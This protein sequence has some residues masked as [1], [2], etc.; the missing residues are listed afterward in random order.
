MTGASLAMAGD[1]ACVVADCIRKADEGNGKPLFVLA[2]AV[3]FLHAAEL[4]VVPVV[5]ELI[6]LIDVV[7]AAA[8]VAGLVPVAVFALEGLAVV[9]AAAVNEIVTDDY[10]VSVVAAAVSILHVARVFWPQQP[11]VVIHFDLVWRWIF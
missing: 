2:V 6:D 11:V 10:F 9:V 8:V 3:Y 7:V 5:I 4:A 1:V